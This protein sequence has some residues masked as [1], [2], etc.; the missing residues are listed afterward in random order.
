[1]L[2]SLLP[3]PVLSLFLS[4]AKLGELWWTVFAS[5]AAAVECFGQGA[6]QLALFLT[7]LNSLQPHCQ[8]ALLYTRLTIY[9]ILCFCCLA[10]LKG[11]VC[12]SRQQHNQI[13]L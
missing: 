3:Y 8:H 10:S 4:L 12:L 1:M 5:F 6:S 9:Q 13:V 11:G 2:L 7:R